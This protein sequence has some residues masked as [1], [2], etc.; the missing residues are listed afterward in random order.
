MN[1]N[2]ITTINKLY[3]ELQLIIKFGYLVKLLVI[4]QNNL[5]TNKSKGLNKNKLN[6]MKLYFKMK[7]KVFLLY[8]LFMLKKNLKLNF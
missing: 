4:F 2:N 1:I 6:F 8:Q 7:T 3:I 5:K